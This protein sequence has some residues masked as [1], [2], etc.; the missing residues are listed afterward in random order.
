M[1]GTVGVP[2]ELQGGRHEP[3]EGGGVHDGEGDGDRE[4]EVG[5]REGGDEDVARR[6]QLGPAHRR[7]HHRQVTRHCRVLLMLLNFGN[8][9]LFRG[10]FFEN[11]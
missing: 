9:L 7:Q 6:P 1:C 2:A 4:Q 3:G 5:Q 8:V 10:V 11:V